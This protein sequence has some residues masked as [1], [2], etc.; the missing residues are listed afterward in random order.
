MNIKIST[1]GLYQRLYSVHTILIIFNIFLISINVFAFQGSPW[2][3]WSILIMPCSFVCH[4]H[5]TI[6][7]QELMQ[8]Y[9]VCVDINA[10]EIYRYLHKLTG[11][12]QRTYTHT[13]KNTRTDL[14]VYNRYIL[15]FCPMLPIY[16]PK[17]Q[18]RIKNF[19]LVLSSKYF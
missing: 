2:V 8:K 12:T 14:P 15:Y 18:K 19:H 1:V 10:C 3:Y 17:E 6:I 13:N 7:T 11:H 5:T 9:F 4:T 16:E